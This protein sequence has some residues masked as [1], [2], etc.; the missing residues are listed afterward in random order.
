[1]K[2]TLKMVAYGVALLALIFLVQ[3]L[4]A[5]EPILAG[6]AKVVKMAVLNDTL[7]SVTAYANDQTMFTGIQL[8]PVAVHSGTSSRVE[9]KTYLTLDK[10]TWILHKTFTDA[11]T[12]GVTDTLWSS[13]LNGGVQGVKCTMTVTEYDSVQ[14]TPYLLQFDPTE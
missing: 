3:T 8:V 10:R 2:S 7:Q 12:S 1:M 14:V 13:D 11:I 5:P 9:I 4:T 6:N